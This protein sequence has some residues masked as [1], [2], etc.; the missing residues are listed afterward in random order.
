MGASFIFVEPAEWYADFH[1][2][3]KISNTISAIRLFLISTGPSI[4]LHT[5]THYNEDHDLLQM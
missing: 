3:G 4:Q 1:Y 2:K 5:L